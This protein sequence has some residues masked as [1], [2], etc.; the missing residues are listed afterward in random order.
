MAGKPG[1][2]G[3]IKPKIFVVQTSSSAH[4]VEA[5]TSAAAIE[6]VVGKTV[7]AR[8]ATSQDMYEAGKAGVKVESAVPKAE[9]AADAE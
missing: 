4:L 2:R 5:K 1:T 9:P 7:T 6:Y 3:E 8:L